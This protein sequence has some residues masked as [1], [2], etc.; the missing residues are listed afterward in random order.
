MSDEKSVEEIAAETIAA[1]EAEKSGD[2][3]FQDMEAIPS[4]PPDDSPPQD[5]P[6]DPPQDPP[7][8]DDDDPA[9]D[10]PEVE[11]EARSH[12]WKPLEEFVEAGGDPNEWSGASAFMKVYKN[13]GDMRALERKIRED[14]KIAAQ[15]NELYRKNKEDLVDRFETRIQ[16][17]EN[18]LT[19]A[20]ED[21]DTEKVRQVAENLAKTKQQKENYQEQLKSD[22]IYL[23]EKT[24]QYVVPESLKQRRAQQ[25]MDFASDKPLIN[26]NED[27]FNAVF[28][29]AMQQNQTVII[30]RM[31][32]GDLTQV[33]DQMAE[34]CMQQAYEKTLRDYAAMNPQRQPAQKQPSRKPPA[35]SKA[36]PTRQT[37]KQSIS[38]LDPEARDLYDIILEGQGK[39]AAEDFLNSMLA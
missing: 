30:N 21:M 15:V 11:K 35:T 31:C 10:V 23:D 16:E 2:P 5:P 39:E 7:A 18:Q 12:G 20:A 6:V 33:D 24:G 37:Q 29:Q 22:E 3:Q 27:Q 19:E 8:D 9:D 38:D 26:P 13:V 28:A 17:L 1:I 4:D 25:A 36:K 32:Q 14:K 34:D